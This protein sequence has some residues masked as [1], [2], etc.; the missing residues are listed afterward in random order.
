MEK[1]TFMNSSPSAD[2]KQE[3]R[4]ASYWTR[5][6]TLHTSTDVPTGALN[7]NVD[8]RSTVGP[9]QGFGYL[10]Q[11]T[12]TLTV[13]KSPEITLTPIEIMRNWKANFP[14][15]MP[16]GQ[17]FY[18]LL[19]GI[20][21]GQAITI[22]PGQ[23]ILVNGKAGM[24]VST[25]MLVLYADDEAF[26]LMTS[27]GHPESGWNTFSVSDLDDTIVCQVQ[28]LARTNDPIYELGFHLFGSDIQGAFWPLVLKNLAAHLHL[29]GEIQSSKECIDPHFQW[30]QAKNIWYNAAIH[31]FFY[32]LGTPLRALGKRRQRSSPPQPASP[33][34]SKLL[35]EE[36]IFPKMS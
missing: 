6:S 8:G 27:Q 23:V 35:E 20:E 5:T 36:P 17:R 15:F 1:E 31:T 9:L 11:R 34:Q 3:A 33:V 10:W 30:S 19:H 24:L 16:P 28:S 13:K 14:L 4:D 12:Y 2:E 7:L 29:I 32:M 21:P 18:P 25:G 26:T 22:E